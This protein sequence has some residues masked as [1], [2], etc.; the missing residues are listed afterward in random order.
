MTLFSAAEQEV[1]TPVTCFLSPRFMVHRPPPQVKAS[2]QASA[3]GERET[4]WTLS[5]GDWFG[6]HALKG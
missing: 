6:E 4:E 2:Q 1:C 5:E 3:D